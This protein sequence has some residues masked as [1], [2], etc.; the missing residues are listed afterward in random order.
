MPRIYE[1]T[2]IRQGPLHFLSCRASA[3]LQ[4]IPIPSLFLFQP[5]HTVS[6]SLA[7]LCPDSVERVAVLLRHRRCRVAGQGGVANPAGRCRV[8]HVPSNPYGRWAVQRQ[9]RPAKYAHLHLLLTLRSHSMRFTGTQGVH[10]KYTIGS[11]R[12]KGWESWG[13]VASG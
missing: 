13:R 4:F 5:L 3:H 7:Y 1:L 2:M 8:P 11:G 12:G 9:G 10:P 6:C